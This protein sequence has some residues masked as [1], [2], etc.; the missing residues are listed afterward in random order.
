MPRYRSS[1]VIFTVY[2]RNYTHG[3]SVSSV[4]LCCGYTYGCFSLYIDAFFRVT[5]TATA[6]KVWLYLLFFIV[7]PH[8]RL[9]LDLRLCK[10]VLVIYCT[11]RSY[12]S[13]F[14]S[15]QATCI[16]DNFVVIDSG[17][18]SISLDWH[19]IMLVKETLN[20]LHQRTYGPTLVHS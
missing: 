1:K 16:N 8:P 5:L 9:F 4:S 2:H 6:T 10:L 18:Q 19:W 13:T 15:H 14:N 12:Q 7:K 17:H 3:H 11:Y 20:N